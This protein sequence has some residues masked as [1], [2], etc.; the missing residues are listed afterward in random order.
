[1]LCRALEWR[2]REEL[3]GTAVFSPYQAALH[4]VG[5]RAARI[6]QPQVDFDRGP[7]QIEP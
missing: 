7:E 5:H 3:V 1:M 6:R 4:N 2:H